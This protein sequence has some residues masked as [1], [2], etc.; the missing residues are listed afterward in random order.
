[1]LSVILSN[2]YITED[3]HICQ[4]VSKHTG[5]DPSVSFIRSYM[6]K[7]QLPSLFIVPQF[8]EYK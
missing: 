1:M 3:T 8:H 2:Y 4:S 7:Y 6:N 5:D